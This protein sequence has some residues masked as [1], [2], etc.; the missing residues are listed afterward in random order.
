MEFISVEKFIK[1]YERTQLIKMARIR[2]L[3][4][5]ERKAELEGERKAKLE[6]AKKLLAQNYPV[7]DIVSATG[8]S[9]KT[10]LSIGQQ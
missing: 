3:L 8:L 4:E 6:I 2:G 7:K 1:E 10:I 5:G 9:K